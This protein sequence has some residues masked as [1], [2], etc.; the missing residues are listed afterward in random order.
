MSDFIGNILSRESEIIRLIRLFS[1]SKLDFIVVGGYAVSV[2]KKR[3]SADLDIVIK[4]FDA[5][6]FESLLEKEGYIHGYSKEISTVYGEKF[7]RF[8]KK[9]GKMTVSV[10][11]LINGVVSRLSGGSWGFEMLLENSIKSALQGA[12]FLAP[13]KEIL[14]AMKIHSGRF[15]DIRDI[16]AL[17]EDIDQTRPLF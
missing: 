1:A 4:E 11:F 10:D 7:R 15:S 3:F 16:V 6:K 5:G 8:E 12:E 14:I 9:T 13:A 17:Y 2:H